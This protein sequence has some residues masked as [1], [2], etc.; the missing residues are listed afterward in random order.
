[1]SAYVIGDINVTNPEVFAEYAGKVPASSGAYGGKYLV[2]GP[3]KCEPCEGDWNP[4]RFVLAEYKDV[5]TVRS[6]YYSDE[7]K[8]LTKL[9]QSASTGTLLVAE[10][11]EPH[12]QGSDSG[13]AGYIVGDIEVTDPDT[14]SQYAAGVPATVA[15]YGGRYLIR[16]VSG[17]VLEGGW[18]PKRLVVL[19][20]ESIQRAKE[21]Y[22]SPE[23]ADLKKIRQSASKGNLI[24]ADGA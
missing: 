4:K 1:M 21:W 11:V 6:W 9:R 2:R 16:G 8:E 13:K 22:N 5:E 24:F 17:E 10:G 14:Y 18:T 20:F 15:A 7:Y 3:D 12:A 19:E 23:Y